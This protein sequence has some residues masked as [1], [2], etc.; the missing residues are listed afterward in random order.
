MRSRRGLCRGTAARGHLTRF[1][2]A[3]SA[4]TRD[5][6]VRKLAALGQPSGDRPSTRALP[7]R[8]AVEETSAGGERRFVLLR[9]GVGYDVREVWTCRKFLG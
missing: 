3:R 2:L 7:W 4:T 6:T 5:Q 9:H 8:H 1:Y